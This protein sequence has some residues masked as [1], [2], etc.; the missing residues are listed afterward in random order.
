MRRRKHPEQ[1]FRACLGIIR[2]KRHLRCAADRARVRASAALP[3]DLVQERRGDPAAQP[4]AVEPTPPERGSPARCTATSVARTTTT[5]PSVLDRLPGQVSTS[6]P[7]ECAASR[8]ARR[9]AQSPSSGRR[10]APML[11]EQTLEKLR[12]EAARHGHVTWSSGCGAPRQAP[13]PDRPAR[14]ARRRRVAHRDNR[15][16]QLRL[17]NAKLRQQACLE[18]VDY[19]HARGLSGPRMLDLGSCRWVQSQP[20]RAAH[21]PDR[22]RQELPGLR[23]GPQGVP[24]RLHRALPPHLAALDE[25]AQARADGTYRTVLQRFAKA[26]VLILDDFGLEPLGATERKDLLDVLEDRYGISS[27]FSPASSSPSTGTPSSAT[28]PSPTPSAT[29]SSTRPP[30]QA[31]RRVHPQAGRKLTNGPKAAK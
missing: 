9:R 15:K 29:G 24:R 23:A 11:V 16:L 1:G 7:G 18:D 4:G 6:L 30:P 25:L 13:E 21:R 17:K 10:R 14:P 27:T 31:G 28:R 26:Q 8:F 5:E 12:A 22:R 2:L 3:R 19:P 20:E